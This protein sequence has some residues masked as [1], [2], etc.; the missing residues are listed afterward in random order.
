MPWCGRPNAAT[1]AA[2]PHAERS[3]STTAD[4]LRQLPL[5]G[6]KLFKLRSVNLWVVLN[7]VVEAGRIRLLYLYR[8]DTRARDPPNTLSINARVHGFEPPPSPAQLCVLQN[9]AKLLA[10]TKLTRLRPAESK[11]FQ[12]LV[13]GYSR[14]SAL[15]KWSGSGRVGKA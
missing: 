11:R 5:L 3:C 14:I 12:Q 1:P 4:P 13:R 8:G 15:V 7:A 2:P 6:T 9:G 10:G